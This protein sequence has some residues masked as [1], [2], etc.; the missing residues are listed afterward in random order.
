MRQSL[1]I[2]AAAGVLASVALTGCAKASH[3]GSVS[4]NGPIQITMWTHSAG[5]PG[6]LAVYKKILADFNASQSTYQVVEQNFPQGSYNDAITAAATA[7]KL[8]CL[9]DMDGPIMPNWAWA[10]Y[11][12]PLGLPSS[13]IDRLLPT[14]VGRYQGKIY[15]AG[16][17]DAAMAI[18]ARKSV[19]TKA[20]VRVPTVDQPWTLDEFNAVNAKLKSSGYATPLDLGAADKG[21]WWSYAYSPMLESAGGDEID[22]TTM[23]SADGKLN[24]PDAVRFFTWFR[25]VFKNGWANNAGPVGNQNFIDNKVALSYTGVWNAQDALKSVGSDL[26]ILPPVDFGHGAKIGGGSWQ[27]GISTGCGTQQSAGA[28]AY[29]QFSF[30]DKYLTD[31]ADSQV[32]IP[33]TSTAAAASKYFGPNGPLHQFAVLSQKF[34]LGRPATPGYPV[35]STTFEKAAKDIMNGADVKSTLDTAVQAI[36]SDIQSNNNYGS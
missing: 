6:E 10:G 14:T 31:F 33:S 36:D 22:R 32:V 29:L 25:S 27:W 4:G 23:K 35:I 8:P 18:F 17:W 28:R 24:G 30:Q 9:L 5:N 12:Q 20:G 13:L 1:S 34:A 19:L 3:D 26:L 7:H 15:S 16:Y 2:I 21:E 11:L